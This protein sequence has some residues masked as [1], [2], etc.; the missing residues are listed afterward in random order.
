MKRNKVNEL[1]DAL[2]KER[3]MDFIRKECANDIDV[4]TRFLSMGTSE[5]FRPDPAAY[6][7]R[8]DRLMCQYG[9]RNGYIPYNKT[10]EFSS[11]VGRILSE[12]EEAIGGGRWKV[13]FAALLGVADVAED[14]LCC[15]DDSC[16]NLGSLVEECFNGWRNLASRPDL[17][18]DVKAKIFSLAMDKFRSGDL[19]GW[20]WHWNWID[21]AIS[22]AATSAEQNIVQKEI[23]SILDRS[24]KNNTDDYSAR[25][26]YNTARSYKL[27]LMS[28]SCAD[29]Q[30]R[31]YLYQNKDYSDFR[32]KLL[33][34]AWEEGKDDEVLRL[35]QDGLENDKEYAGLM[36]DWRGWEFKVYRKRGDVPN[37]LSLAKFFFF[38][39]TGWRDEYPQE[40]M[41]R[42]MKSLVPQSE[43]RSYVSG[44]IKETRTSGNS[45][46]SYDGDSKLLYIYEQE[47]Y[48]EDYMQYIRD[49][50]SVDVTDS[51][52]SALWKTFKGEILKIYGECVSK[53]FISASG[54]SSYEAGAA[55]LRRLISYGGEAGAKAII[56]EQLSRKPRRPAL[57]EI[58]SKIKLSC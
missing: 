30:I 42:L 40:E 46:H 27:K 44:L 18:T 53:F 7:S 51:A 43:W 14:I 8:I 20:D 50:Q 19:K 49:H 54:R 11:E 34:M 56:E 23:D 6:S 26:E 58:L 38:N 39:A 5:K 36:M 41:Y 57:I 10:F 3:L 29:E 47:E 25:Y 45:R 17:P 21:L 16:G 4:K 31:E 12:A 1:L 13:A 52:P 9:D 48:W 24:A 2:D 22:S 33:Q 37:I 28:K 15:G 32:K 55:M 35:A